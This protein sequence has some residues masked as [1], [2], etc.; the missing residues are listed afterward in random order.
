MNKDTLTSAAAK[1]ALLVVLKD[2]DAADI[3]A[4]INEQKKQVER[5][6]LLQPFKDMLSESDAFKRDNP[7]EFDAI[8]AV[9]PD[10][11]KRTRRQLSLMSKAIQQ[12]DLTADELEAV[13]TA[14][15]DSDVLAPQ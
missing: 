15:V 6:A 8:K 9:Y 4:R 1:L 11:D 10:A 2:K 13:I 14:I 7:T 12:K 3:V 5:I